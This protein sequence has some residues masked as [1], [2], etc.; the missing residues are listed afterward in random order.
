[1]WSLIM[2]TNRSLYSWSFLMMVADE[3]LVP[4]RSSHALIL[5]NAVCGGDLL[6]RGATGPANLWDRHVWLAWV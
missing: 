3:Y 6:A 5:I 1:M 4:S 2:R